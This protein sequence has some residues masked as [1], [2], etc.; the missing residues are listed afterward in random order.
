M[1]LYAKLL[2][3]VFTLGFTWLTTW[4]TN[5][6]HVIS[7]IITETLL[8][9]ELIN[10]NFIEI[11]Y[12]F[13]GI[14]SLFMFINWLI[15][16][17]NSKSQIKNIIINNTK[18]KINNFQILH[19]ELSSN[20]E[21]YLTKFKNDGNQIYLLHTI[22]AIYSY[23][24][25]HINLFFLTVA[26]G[27]VYIYNDFRSLV[28][29]IAFTIMAIYQHIS[30]NWIA[31]K[32]Q[33]RINNESIKFMIPLKNKWKTVYGEKRMIKRGNIIELDSKNDIPC[34]ILLL[35]EQKVFVN[36][37]EL[38]GENVEIPKN[39]LLVEDLTLSTIKDITLNIEHHKNKGYVELN[40]KLY[41]YDNDNIVFRGTKI[42]DGKIFGIPIEV[43]NDCQI[44]RLD[45]NIN[46]KDTSTQKLIYNICVKNLSILVFVA[47][48]ISVVIKDKLNMDFN[49]STIVQNLTIIILLLNTMIPLSLQL[50][51]NVSSANISSKLSKKHNVK[52]NSHGIRCFQYEPHFIVTDKTGTLTTN[53]IKLANVYYNSELISTL[54]KNKSGI[55]LNL[56]SCSTVGTHSKT[57]ELLKSDQ[58]EVLMINFGKKN[59]CKLVSNHVDEF[60]GNC[61]Y[62]IDSE[63]HEIN[64]KYYK[65]LLYT[66]GVKVSILETNS[67]YFMHIQ[68][69]PEKIA[70]YLTDNKQFNL[71]LNSVENDNVK[72]ANYYKRIISHAS[73]EIT[74]KD[75]DDII[76][77]NI[78]PNEY[79]TSFSNWSLY[80]FHDYIVTNIQKSIE[81]LKQKKYDLTMLTGDKQSSALNVGK[82]IGLI[83]TDYQIITT[84]NETL[85]SK[86]ILIEGKLVNELINTNSEELKYFV[87]NT[88]NRIIFRADPSCKQ[89]FISFLKSNYNK[90]VMMVGDGSNDISALIMADVGVGIIG[91]NMTVQYISDILTSTWTK[92][93]GLLDDFKKRKTVI[94][95]I[96]YWVV[97]KHMLTAFTLIGMLIVSSCE[98]L[99]DPTSP[100]LVIFMNTVLFGYM[101]RYSKTEE[102]DNDNNI[103]INTSKWKKQGIFLGI[104]NG[105]YVFTTV[106]YQ[107]GITMAIASTLLQLILKLYSIE[108]K[109]TVSVKLFYA[110]SLFIVITVLKYISVVGSEI[111]WGYL[112]LSYLFYIMADKFIK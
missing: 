87:S 67:K 5:T 82:T 31:I 44:F 65:S 27:Q 86:S 7:T 98:Q 59:N 64:R 101:V 81:D 25:N 46:K 2:L 54:D 22:H 102:N 55:F 1:L 11:L 18:S 62:I 14:L 77:G 107:E 9:I 73:K 111:F 15:N 104:F 112:L 84:P 96:C 105:L 32:Q 51:Y 92:I 47:S 6:T 80:V 100:Y 30:E 76:S 69:M 49:I 70:D 12:V 20:N 34:D 103:I 106:G 74:Q 83:E 43:G 23:Y 17:H 89:K 8:A 4:L 26:M 50:F 93:P 99:K 48:I 57:G 39:G 68:G 88:T 78:S 52:I 13:F 10:N 19:N 21:V 58:L 37:L 42:I 38:T 33:L 108:S 41:N 66:Y 97:M 3:F 72:D 79:L 53:E 90:D 63:L 29:L 61:K 85:T 60:S 56:I 40:N 24:K 36:E 110:V 35:G 16:K 91:E 109:K 28:P 71:C 45:Y 94:N 95:N 75:Y